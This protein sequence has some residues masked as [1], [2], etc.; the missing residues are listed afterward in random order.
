MLVQSIK[1]A[2]KCHISSIA[3]FKANIVLTLHYLQCAAR[4]NS[5]RLH[6]LAGSG[7]HELHVGYFPNL[8]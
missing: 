8:D 5:S 3:L 2:Q 4:T 6:E 7:L 1:F